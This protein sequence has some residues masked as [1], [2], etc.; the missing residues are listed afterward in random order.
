VSAGELFLADFVADGNQLSGLPLFDVVQPQDSILMTET[1]LASFGTRSW[2]GIATVPGSGQFPT[3]ENT[4]NPLDADVPSFQ[5]QA[6]LLPAGSAA[7][8]FAITAFNGD[9]FTTWVA[10]FGGFVSPNEAE[11]ASITVRRIRMQVFKSWSPL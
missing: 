2:A 6:S 5:H 3:D 9:F 7:D 11:S 4:P 10:G 8:P 1:N